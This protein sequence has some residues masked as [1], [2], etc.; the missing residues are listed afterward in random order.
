MCRAIYREI[1]VKVLAIYESRGDEYAAIRAIEGKPFYEKRIFPVPT[2]F[3]T[4]LVIDLSDF[5]EESK[6]VTEQS[7]LLSM[8]R[9]NRHH[10]HYRKLP[11]GT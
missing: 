11:I 1:P 4:V 9:A 6:P 10:L 7:N 8:A 3:E 5:S 2:E